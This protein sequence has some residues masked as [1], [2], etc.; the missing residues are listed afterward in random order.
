MQNPGP[1]PTPAPFRTTVQLGPLQNLLLLLLLIKILK[2]LGLLP[3]DENEDQFTSTDQV[4]LRVA[5]VNPAGLNEAMFW[6]DR[7]LNGSNTTVS[8]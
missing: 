6:R 2:R 8:I 5:Q 1:T 7:L 3:P 4:L